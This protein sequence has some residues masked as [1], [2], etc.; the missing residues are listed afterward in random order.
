MKKTHLGKS[1]Y[2]TSSPS[3][4]VKELHR[5]FRIPYVSVDEVES[6]FPEWRLMVAVICCYEKDE[7]DILAFLDRFDVER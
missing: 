4:I 2:T 1:F 5:E 3:A 6:D 7:N